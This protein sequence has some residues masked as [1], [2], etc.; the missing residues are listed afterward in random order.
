GTRGW[1]PSGPQRTAVPDVWLPDTALYYPFGLGSVSPQ[2][3][4]LHLTHPL[5]FRQSVPGSWDDAG[6]FTGPAAL[7]YNSDSVNV[8][9]II[10]A[11][12]TSPTGGAVPNSFDVQL[13]WNNGTPQT[14]VNFTTTGHSSGDTYLFA[15]QVNTAVTTTGRYPWT[16]QITA[17][18]AGG[19][20]VVRS[21]SGYANVVANGSSDPVGHRW[22]LSALDQVVT[23]SGG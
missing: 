8:K 3:G 6:Q 10:E 7:V 1:I 23:D 20:T 9:P 21:V 19:D 18:L 5:D 22:G 16:V 2:T 13:T 11:T 4:N 17:N 14:A 15:V 12:L